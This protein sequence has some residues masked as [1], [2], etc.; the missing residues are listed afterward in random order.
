MGLAYSTARAAKN[1]RVL[2]TCAARLGRVAAGPDIG[3]AAG[4]TK[5]VE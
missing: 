5:G 3:V 4:S 1:C 2:P